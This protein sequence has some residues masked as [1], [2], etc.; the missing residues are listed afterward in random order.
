MEKISLDLY[1]CVNE[2]FGKGIEDSLSLYNLCCSLEKEINITYIFKPTIIPYFYGKNLEDDGVSCFCIFKEKSSLGFITLH[3]FNKRKVAY[4]DMVS[5]KKYLNVKEKICKLLNPK[6]I[7]TGEDFKRDT[8]GIELTTNCK[9]LHPL[10]S[11]ILYDLCQEIIKKINMT[12]IADTIVQ[13]TENIIFVTTLIAESHIAIFYNINTKQLY[14]DIFSCKYYDSKN[15]LQILE[16][17]KI[18]VKDYKIKSRGI[19]HFDS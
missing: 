16:N 18:V 6:I 10:N 11:D 12:Q 13:K 4:F 17:N 15:V 2:Y 5:S 3:T 8:W 14:V 19:H 7:K 1:G 9:C